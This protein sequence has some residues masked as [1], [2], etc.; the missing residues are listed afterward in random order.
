MIK[1]VRLALASA[2]A[3]IAAITPGLAATNVPFSTYI[4]GQPAASSFTGAER[5]VI[6]KSGTIQTMTPAQ[7]LGLVTGDC[8]QPGA[9]IVCTKTNGVPFAASATT[10]ATNASNIGSGTLN[11]ARLPAPFTS[12]TASG[13]TSIMATAAAGAKTS[14]HLATWDA[15]GNV[16]DGG[17][18]S[19]NTTNYVTAA[20][21]AKTSGHI[22]TW[23]ASGNVQDGGV[24]GNGTVTEVKTTSAT[25]NITLSGNCDV[26]STNSGSPCNIDLSSA[27]K[28]L[29]TTQKFTSGS[30]TY[31]TP[32][33]ALWIEVW[34]V[35]A[36]AGSAGSGTSPGSS[37]AGGDTCWNT[38]GAACTSP[39]YRAS[40]GGAA[41][42]TAGGTSSCTAGSST[43]ADLIAG[44]PGGSGTTI[45]NS[46]GGSGGGTPFGS[47]GSQGTAG[48][49]GNVG[50]GFGAGAGGAGGGGAG[51]S[52]GGGAG[53]CTF[54]AIINSPAGT[55][56][57]AVGAAGAAGSAGTSGAAGAAGMGGYITVVEHYGS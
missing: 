52:G 2:F 8:S 46:S 15:S 45:A 55:Y 42:A 30:G 41:S 44:G 4:A 11:S 29:P 32:A 54:H 23:D 49:T 56:T 35:G 6:L 9:S 28:T 26:T 1:S 38:S 51:N 47:G 37:G 24:G 12:A 53:G 5:L 18:P 34:G 57:Y 50:G 19:G 3:L 10:D 17:T 21:G 25:A 13:N 48:N 43:P 16:Q 27:R 36:G 39:V 31:T 22:A 14:G 20:A 40:G 7:I 33:G